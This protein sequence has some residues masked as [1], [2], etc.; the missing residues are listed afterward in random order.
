[1]S[2]WQTPHAARRTSTSP[3]P[4]S[5]S[6]TSWTTSGCGELLEDGGADLHP[7]TLTRRASAVKRGLLLCAGKRPGGAR[8]LLLAEVEPQLLRRAQ[9]VGMIG[10]EGRAGS[11]ELERAEQVAPEVAVVAR[12]PS[13]LPP[14]PSPFAR[15]SS[16]TRSQNRLHETITTAATAA[17]R[18]SANRTHPFDASSQ[19]P[20]FSRT[21]ANEGFLPRRSR[22]QRRSGRSQLAARP[23]DYLGAVGDQRRDR[24][25]RR[26]RRRRRVAHVQRAPGL[27]RRRSR[28]RAIRRAPRPGRARRPGPASTSAARSSGT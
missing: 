27:V 6:S 1:M 7:P 16:G 23:Q 2:V 15:P 5:S 8:A 18:S 21:P 19:M 4:G 24:Q 13:C 11:L 22:K 3:G 12:R 14:G 10:A 28:R 17:T 9:P 20:A 26:G 25:R